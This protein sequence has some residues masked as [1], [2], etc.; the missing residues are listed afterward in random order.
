MAKSL[1][2]K[3]E[4]QDL[5]F[6]ARD[7]LKNPSIIGKEVV[8]ML[9]SDKGGE[10][11]VGVREEAG[12]A[13][14]IE[15]IANPKE[16]AREL[17]DHLIDTLEPSPTG[18]EVTVE[19]EK[20]G[21]LGSILRINVCPNEERR[22][23]AQIVKGGRHF[24]IRVSD[25]VRPMSREEI[26]QKFI[27]AIVDENKLEDGIEEVVAEMKAKRGR[28]GKMYTSSIWFYI[29]PTDSLHVDI[30][31]ERLKSLL[32]DPVLSENRPMGW[33]F[34]HPHL[35]PRI[36]MGRII[37]GDKD[38]RTEIREDGS[39][40]MV[41]GIK[42]LYWQ[43]GEKEIS[44]WVLLELPTS[45]VR[46]ASVIY[47]RWLDEKPG[48]KILADFSLFGI[49]G[50][51]LRKGSPNTPK[52]FIH[53]TSVF[54]SGEDIVFPRPMMFSLNQV[55]SEPDRCAFRIVRKIYEEF[56]YREEDMPREYDRKAGK[57]VMPR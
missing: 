53:G 26:A 16:A 28:H 7:A 24:T 47:K 22:P 11:W 37:I 27:K 36:R 9:N 33:D 34:T 30:Q 31:D 57:L 39:I 1:L 55:V 19:A 32:R 48:T 38:D 42:R 50:W 18:S 23:Y 49:K 4:S 10:I 35:E 51:S 8:A 40:L 54:N 44:P 46:L 14:S 41:D 25:R 3:K 2:G 6:K 56:G 5:E 45:L 43:G 15:P 12:S 17:T 52:H 21:S 13:K 20:I 29:R